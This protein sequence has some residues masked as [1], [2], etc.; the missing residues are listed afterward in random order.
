MRPLDVSPG[1]GLAITR[2]PMKGVSSQPT[3]RPLVVR[4]NPNRHPRRPVEH[5]MDSTRDDLASLRDGLRLLGRRPLL[6]NV[7]HQPRIQFELAAEI[8]GIDSGRMWAMMQ[9]GRVTTTYVQDGR[10]HGIP[11][12]EIARLLATRE[13][14]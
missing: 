14:A 2:N 6:H 10:Y 8:L 3:F 4:R 5:E 11:A 9:A 13:F 7:F 1:P 12:H